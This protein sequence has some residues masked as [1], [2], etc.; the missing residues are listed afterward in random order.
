MRK[1]HFIFIVAVLLFALSSS[2]FAAVNNKYFRADKQYFDVETGQYV[3]SGNIVIHLSNGFIA[4]DKARVKLSTLEF[5]GTGGWTLKQD[6]VTFK[7]ESAY[8]VFGKNSAMIEG[9]A[10]FQRPDL[11]ITADSVD[12]NWKT[13]IAEFKGNVKVVQTG[14]APVGSELV[15]Y[16]VETKEFVN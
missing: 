11:Q 9:G 6:D 5:W 7:G 12:Y 8:V 14:Q 2:C 13:K 15:R 10:D 3:I 16:N 1:Y 4:G